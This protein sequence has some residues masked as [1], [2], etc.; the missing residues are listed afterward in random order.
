MSPSSL[1]ASLISRTRILRKEVQL[2]E[3]KTSEHINTYRKRKEEKREGERE[4]ERKR[5]GE[6]ESKRTIED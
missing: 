5:E 2:S 1:N 6:R 3:A 4:R